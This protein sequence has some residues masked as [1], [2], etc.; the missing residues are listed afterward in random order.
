MKYYNL[1][2]FHQVYPDCC[3][4]FAF[5]A[6]SLYQTSTCLKRKQF[7][8]KLRIFHTMDSEDGIPTGY[9]L[10]SHTASHWV[11]EELMLLANRCVAT[12]LYNSV[13]KDFSV[14]RNHK[15]PDTKKAR[16]FS[17]GCTLD[18]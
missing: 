5:L 17:G 18:G 15:P 6:K 7:R 9:H 10:E 2:R 8:H 16:F 3:K 1:A 14:L 12:R 13:L 4:C 11:I